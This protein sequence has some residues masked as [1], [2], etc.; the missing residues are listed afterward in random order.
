M[1]TGAPSNTPSGNALKRSTVAGLE[2]SC[3]SYRVPPIWADE[4]QLYQI[5]YYFTVPLHFERGFTRGQIDTRQ[6]VLYL[7][8]TLF[9]LFL[10]VRSLESRRWR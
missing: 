7:S 5:L 1:V 3:T 10:T 4:S 9:C 6:V 2:L 8:V